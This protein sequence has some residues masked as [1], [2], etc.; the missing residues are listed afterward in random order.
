MEREV[1]GGIGRGKTC[2]LKDVSFQ[3]RKKIKIKKIKKIK[4]KKNKINT[5]SKNSM[6]L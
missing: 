2:K 5:S 4:K 6:D 3:K 1:G